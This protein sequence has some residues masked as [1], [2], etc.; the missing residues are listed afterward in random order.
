MTRVVIT[1][2]SK[3]TIILINFGGAAALLFLL[4]IVKMKK[5][6]IGKIFQKAS[7]KI[8]FSTLQQNKK[9]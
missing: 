6:G 3:I 5:T 7:T 9:I 8:E 2:P 4:Q 1:T